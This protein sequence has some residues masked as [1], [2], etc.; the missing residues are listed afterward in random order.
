MIDKYLE[1]YPGLKDYMSSQIDFA[2]N[3]GYVET[4]MGKTIFTEY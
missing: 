2:R 3:K 1:N 4:I